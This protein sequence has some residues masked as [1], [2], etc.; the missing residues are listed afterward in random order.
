MKFTA[1]RGTRDMLPADSRRWHAVEDEV[2]RLCALYG[3][4][5]IR[6]PV[7]EH[8]ELFL[9][10]VGDTTDIVQK[11]M[12]TFTDKGGRS[13]TLKPEGTAG[14]VRSFIENGL[15]N[16]PQPTKLYYL[17]PVFRYESPQ[18]GRL[19][20]HHQFGV[21]TFGAPEASA[22]AEIISL[23]LALFSRLKIGHLSLRINSIGCPEC[24]PSYQQALREF[25]KERLPRLCNDCRQRFG[26]NPLRI[27]DCKEE[28]CIRE[29]EGHPVMLNH[30]CEGCEKHFEAL[31][32][33]LGA[34]GAAYTV[35][36]GIVRGLDY[37]TK[38]VFEIVSDAIGSQGTVCGGGRYDRLIEECGGPPMSGVGFGLGMERLLMVMENQGIAAPEENKTQVFIGALGDAARA[39]ALA[40]VNRLRDQGIRADTDH[41]GRSAKAQFKYMDKAGC[42]LAV[43]LGDQ[44]LISGRAV[45]KDLRGDRA[46][47]CA[48][49]ELV[50]AIKRMLKRNG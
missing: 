32:A 42:E 35:D 47:D 33:H 21:E 13:V 4:H 31:R 17:S 49:E 7:F 37:Y 18:A 30:L 8:T 12:Y 46:E 27:L 39:R 40:L 9:R 25:L 10:G 2:R 29:I 20:Q 24:R 16:D 38:T 1:P 19:R 22:D 11:E 3:F 23:A 43:M 26:T 41:V 6:T 36:T 5:E 28:A 14:V 48:L 34:L 45:I 15:Y 50:P 44:E